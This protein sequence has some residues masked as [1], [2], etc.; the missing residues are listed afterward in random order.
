MEGIYIMPNAYEPNAHG[1]RSKEKRVIQAVVNAGI[2]T[3]EHSTYAARIPAYVDRVL[4]GENLATFDPGFVVHLEICPDCREEYTSLLDL[5]RADAAG[6]LATPP[7]PPAGSWAKLEAALAAKATAATPPLW[8]V[9]E[10][11]VRRLAAQVSLQVDAGKLILATL[12]ALFVPYH[13]LRTAPAGIR[14]RAADDSQAKI[15]EL[16]FPLPEED[17]RIRIIPGTEHN[18][19]STVLAQLE[20]IADQSAL[21]R[22]RISLRDAGGRPLG[23]LMTGADGSALFKDLAAGNYVL[24]VHLGP[25]YDCPFE[26]IASISK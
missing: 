8:E 15:S 11:G 23:R 14:L 2:D 22:V 19:L 6:Q 24:H 16:V 20:R 7:P 3:E 10:S 25:G 9:L 26:V 1:S 13:H 21:E 18:G 17:A 5:L 4:Q 12:P